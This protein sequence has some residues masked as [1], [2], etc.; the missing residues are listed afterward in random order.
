MKKADLVEQIAGL[1]E[2]KRAPLLADVRDEL[3]E[4]IRLVL[5]PRAAHR[6]SRRC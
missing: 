4:D 6:S 5:E 2:A 3:A 1:I